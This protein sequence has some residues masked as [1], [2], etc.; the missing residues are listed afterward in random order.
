MM[1]RKDFLC[2]AAA[3]RAGRPPKCCRERMAQWHYDC[4]LVAEV[5]ARQSPRFDM[6]KFLLA[7]LDTERAPIEN[8]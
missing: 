5:L 1:T 7:C 6:E 3:L 4:R 8:D 2:V